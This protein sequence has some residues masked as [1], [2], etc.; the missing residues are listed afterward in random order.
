MVITPEMYD[1]IY[2]RRE[3]RRELAVLDGLSPRVADFGSSGFLR[4]RDAFVLADLIQRYLPRR[5][6]SPG[7]LLDL[8]CGLGRIGATIARSLRMPLVGVDFS[9]VAVH[10]ASSLDGHFP[11]ARLEALPLKDASVAA[12][13]SH[14]ALYLAG[15][16]A[17]AEAGRVLLS[18]GVLVFTLY[19]DDGGRARSL[20][21]WYRL[22]AA[23]RLEVRET[24]DDT[25]RW[26]TAM[27][28]KHTLRWR[29][30]AAVRRALGAAYQAEI[31]VTKSML[32]LNGQ[33]P[34]IDGVR[35][36][37]IAAVRKG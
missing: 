8:G 30:R 33:R 34:F 17:V 1:S 29:Q 2:E 16:K 27:R 10:E 25:R 15:S 20:E 26:R 11:M 9:A 22:L 18:R 5:R 7:R 32:G 13:V 31:N 14:D 23:S 21:C 36:Y 12:A 6:S 28:R 24:R 19:T 37:I 35:R 4:G 3:Q